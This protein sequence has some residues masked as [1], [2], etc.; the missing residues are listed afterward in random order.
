MTSAR[1][2]RTPLPIDEAA[3]RVRADAGCQFD[4]AVVAAFD[5]TE[6]ELRGMALAYQPSFNIAHVPED[7]SA[8]TRRR[9][10]A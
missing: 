1:P 7:L 4:G 6:S 10:Q 5:R 2:Y 9:M 3:R 8:D